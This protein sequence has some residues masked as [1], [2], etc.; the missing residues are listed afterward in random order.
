MV[1][2]VIIDCL[3]NANHLDTDGAVGVF[4][5]LCDKLTNVHS[6]RTGEVDGLPGVFALCTEILADHS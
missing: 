5:I 4:I 3:F 6:F 1:P 2:L